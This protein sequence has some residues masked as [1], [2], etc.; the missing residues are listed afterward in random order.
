MAPSIAMIA[1]RSTTPA[2][3]KNTHFM[4]YLFRRQTSHGILSV[5]YGNSNCAMLVC[6]VGGLTIHRDGDD[7]LAAPLE[8][9][10]QSRIHL[11]ESGV[12][13]LWPGGAA[14]GG[15]V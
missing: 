1:T 13:A 12:G 6:H 4:Q 2:P 15:A 10:G 5:L 9:S 3:I 8:P 11:V 7:Q 14:G